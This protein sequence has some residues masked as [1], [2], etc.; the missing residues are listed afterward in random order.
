M[1]RNGHLEWIVNYAPGKLEAVAYKKG[2]S[3]LRWVQTTGEPY[4]IVV[5]PTRI[6]YWPTAGMLL[7]SYHRAGQ[8][9]LEVPMRQPAS[10]PS[11]EMPGSWVGNGDPQP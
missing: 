1:P 2:K 10:F 3:L 7:Y 6:P 4:R 11:R 9:R 5:H 8:T